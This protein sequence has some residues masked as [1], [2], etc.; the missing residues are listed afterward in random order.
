MLLYADDILDADSV[1]NNEQS[2]PYNI[3]YNNLDSKYYPFIVSS[4]KFYD[5]DIIDIIERFDEAEKKNAFFV[6][7]MYG[8]NINMF[9]PSLNIGDNTNLNGMQYVVN[10]S[11]FGFHAGYQKYT[12]KVLPINSFGYQVYIDSSVSFGKNGLFFTS[13]NADV[14]WDFFDN[15]SVVASLNMGIGIGATKITGLK[16]EVDNY[17]VAYRINLGISTRIIKYSHRIGLY[18][19]NLQGLQ[20]GLMSTT[21][22]FGY[23]YVF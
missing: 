19:G 8:I 21:I 9:I 5:K 22:T 1:K 18:L 4:G 15:K 2:N 12:S 10:P 7:I 13:I 3:D 23:D 17:E 11:L 16:M 20:R 6:G 14:L